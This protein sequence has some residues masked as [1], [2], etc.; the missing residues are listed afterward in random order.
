M[1]NTC[2]QINKF[3]TEDFSHLIFYS[4][5]DQEMKSYFFQRIKLHSL[6]G[7]NDIYIQ[8][9]VIHL[10]LFKVTFKVSF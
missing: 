4:D 1:E 8:N 10:L 5:N 7:K 9:N 6:K 2:K 3:K